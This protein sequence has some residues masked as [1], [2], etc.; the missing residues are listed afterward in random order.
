MYLIY[1]CMSYIF[2]QF[3]YQDMCMTSHEILCIVCVG[4][5]R[6]FIYFVPRSQGL[7]WQSCTIG[8]Y[9]CSDYWNYSNGGTK[10]SIYSC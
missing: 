9:C 5:V 10:V 7:T 6:R 3:R 2:L 8:K 1:A 4:F